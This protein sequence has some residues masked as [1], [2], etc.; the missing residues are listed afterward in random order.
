MD[1]ASWDTITTTAINYG[2]SNAGDSAEVAI[3]NPPTSG[4]YAGD[5]DYYQ[6]T[7]T[8]DVPKF[9]L[10][11]V[12][13][14]EW[15]V[16]ANATAKI[17]ADG[18]GAGILA[19]NSDAGG[20]QT[21]GS[22]RMN[23]IG[24]SIVSNYNINTSGNTRLTASGG[25]SRTMVSRRP[26]RPCWMVRRA[27]TRTAPEVP[28]PLLELLEPPSLPAFPGNPVPTVN[29]P[30]VSCTGQTP[31]WWPPPQA[32]DY[33]ATPGRYAGGGSGCVTIQGQPGPDYVF[34]H[35]DYRFQGGAGISLPYER[36]RFEGGVYNFDGGSGISINGS[37]PYFE[38]EA[39]MYSFTGGATISIGGSA[40]NNILGGGAVDKNENY[41]YFSG[42]GGIVT[43]GSNRLTLYPGTYIF[44][45][46]PGISMSGSAQLEFMPGTYEFWFGNGADMRFTGSSRVTLN[47]NPY[48]KTYFYGTQN[49]MS[50]F[51][52][53]GSTSFHVPSGEYYFDRGSMINTGSATI[54]GEGV[55]LYFKNGGR[56]FSTGS[57]SFAF[58]ALDTEIYTGFYPG[59]YMY[60]DRANTATFQWFGTT[61]TVST[62]IVYLPSSPLVMGGA[63]NGKAWR[64]QLIADRFQ[65]SGSNSTDIEYVKYV[66]MQVPVVA[67]VE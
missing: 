2:E 60:S 29:P 65:L 12:Y 32:D 58:T 26:A 17:G 38:M 30:N 5:D 48:V 39:G 11:A 34:P 42:G 50:D 37:T 66:E 10:G 28:D 52:M 19:L 59:V 1:G 62:G 24:G 54:V 31:G 35:G 64:G 55:F 27:R 56:V 3:A 8:K 51:D 43:G 49:N 41:F 18:F 57:A 7:I 21:A 9:F 6:V 22:S 40:P 13:P 16:T 23:V 53:S 63:S 14:G 36:I 67:L 15:Y 33:F 44:D 25:L 20:I 46:G 45:G 47:G 61:S 4:T